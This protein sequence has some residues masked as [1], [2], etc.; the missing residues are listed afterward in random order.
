MREILFRGKLLFTGEWVYGSY[1]PD[2]D[3]LDENTAYILTYE[4]NDPDYVYEKVDLATVGQYTGL[5]DKNGKKVYEADILTDKFGSMGGVE[6]RDGGF[7]VNFGDM[8]IFD[9]SDCFGD[10]YQMWVIGNI[11]DNADLIK[12]DEI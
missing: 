8:D 1:L 5:K 11:H 7:V 2:T 10:S 6:W 3:T 4:L 9:L 12:I